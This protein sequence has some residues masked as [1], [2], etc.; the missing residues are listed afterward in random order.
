MIKISKEPVRV[1]DH[2]VLRYL[3]RAMGLNIEI[4]REHIAS[5]CQGPAA[6]GASCVRS[7]GVRFEINTGVV[8]T[9][10]VDMGAQPSRTGQERNAAII[11]RKK[12]ECAI[13]P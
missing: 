2:A 7:E 11:R 1:S 6:L 9:T 8:V 4:V 10:A 13:S 12:Q 3:E 5:I